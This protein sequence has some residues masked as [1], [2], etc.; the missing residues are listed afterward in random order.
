MFKGGIK[1][2]IIEKQTFRSKPYV[3]ITDDMVRV[4]IDMTINEWCIFSD[5]FKQV[6]GN[7]EGELSYQGE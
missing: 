4:T 5:V 2:K 3:N 1:M 6:K 7:E